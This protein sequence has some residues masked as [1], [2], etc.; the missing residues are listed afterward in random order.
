M[1]S[2]EDMTE[3]LPQVG[4]EGCPRERRIGPSDFEGLP[5]AARIGDGW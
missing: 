3:D 1:R 2:P 4:Q 5:S